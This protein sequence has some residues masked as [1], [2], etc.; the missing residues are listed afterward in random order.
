MRVYF[1]GAAQVVTGSNYLIETEE[2]KFLVDCGQFQGNIQESKRNEIPFQ[3][4]PKE[5][6]FLVLTHAHIDHSGRI[7]KLVK[8]GFR[9]RIIC[10]R[11][12]A[13]LVEI[14]LRDSGHIHE[15]EAE[16][17]NKKRMRAGLP[18]IEPYYTVDDAIDAL[19][20]LNPVDFNKEVQV[21]PHVKTRLR[22]AG[23]LLGAASI[24]LWVTEQNKT[25]KLVFSGDLGMH[26]IPMLPQPD[27]I[28]E[29]DYIFVESTYGNRKHTQIEERVSNLITVLNE[30]ISKGGTA[31]IPAFAVGR[32]QEIIFELNKYLINHPEL[33]DVLKV[34]FY[35]DSPLAI[36]ATSIFKKNSDYLAPRVKAAFDKGENPI[37]LPK[38]KLVQE[39]KASM[40]LNN[41]PEPKVIISAS[42]MCDAG[43]IKHHLKHY[44]WRPE[45]ALIFVGF[46]GEGTLGRQIKSGEEYVEIFDETIK[47]NAKIVSI[48]GFSG[49]ADADDLLNWL[50]G[51]KK[52][53]AKVVIIHGELDSQTAFSKRI[54]EE[55][56]YETL[57][58]SINDV[59][60]IT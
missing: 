2:T 6:D 48:D 34:P 58:P 45:T 60:E 44:L 36:N 57:I 24:E 4:D 17:E 27:T 13:E 8:E 51:F 11:P 21:N 55:L 31:I 59:L 14:L 32:T 10:T 3:F 22:V 41:D 12:T 47:V 35:V 7:P 38:L 50:K 37:D 5:V 40:V 15:A 9:G 28:D 1:L 33:S 18:K 20:Y 53:P 49:H 23:H 25:H 46:Q 39:I 30:T 16:W 52:P 42:G 26:D 29:A 19:Q 56:K 54:E 43:R